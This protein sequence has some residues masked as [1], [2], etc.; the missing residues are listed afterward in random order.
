MTIQP[1]RK[2]HTNALTMFRDLAEYV[3]IFVPGD[4]L[5]F[6]SVFSLILVFYLLGGGS[7]LSSM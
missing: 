2:F 6:V 4:V 7:I 5:I 3:E 1:R